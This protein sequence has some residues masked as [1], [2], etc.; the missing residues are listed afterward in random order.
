VN[1]VVLGVGFLRREGRVRALITGA[2]TAA[3]SG[4]LLVA[5]AVAQF[6]GART[7]ALADADG[8]VFVTSSRGSEN[9][10]NLLADGGVRPG[11]VFA[12][13]LICLVPLTLLQQAVR[14]GTAAR[15]RRLAG[16]RLAGATP[17]QV[18]AL[19]AVEVG[20]PAGI[21]ALLGW[22][23]YLLLRSL[24]GGAGA[25]RWSGDPDVVR[26]LRLVPTSVAPSWWQVVLVASVV[27]LTGIAA[28]VL[29]SRA[30]VVSPLGL[31]RGA[32]GS[33]PRPWLPFAL[34]AAGAVL[35][36]EIY[37]AYF[38]AWFGTASALAG[39]GCAIVGILMVAPWGAY[40]AGRIV[41]RRASSPALLIAARRLMAEPRPAGRAAAATGAIALVAGGAITLV[42]DLAS[43]EGNREALYVV[44]T[45]AVFLLLLL[46]LV[47]T[48]FTLA[49]HGVE[50]LAD[51]KRS[52]AALT[53]TGVP[54]AV[55][56]RAQRWEAALVSLPVSVAGVAVTGLGTAPF[57]ASGPVEMVIRVILVACVLGLIWL[58]L[59]VST[60]AV[61][62]WLLRAVSPENLR[63]A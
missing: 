26:E 45:A 49:V 60:R 14:L 48:T 53:A 57:L 27:C 15:E 22:P 30:L 10:A 5:V 38:D 18:R 37:P 2:C 20:I 47:V 54:I 40:R 43:G 41:A 1:L 51:R 28:G 31:S 7:T 12:L 55:L 17:G 4:L 25:D 59:I 42:A 21:G 61:R 13:V 52:L 36:L 6:G 9:V 24:F 16:L 56:E 34:L 63:T 33:P 46:A 23:V 11:Y 32:A 35:M 8:T 62:P 39:V 29:A 3:V 44:P 50:S 19:A 58:A